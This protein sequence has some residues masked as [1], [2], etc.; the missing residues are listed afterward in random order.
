MKLSEILKT[1]GI[2]T[3]SPEV[4][5][6]HAIGKLSSSHDAA[7]V[8]DEDENLLGVI[9][10]FHCLIN[11]S[12]P[13]NAKVVNCL[14]KPPKVYLDTN[15]A[16]VARLMGESKIHYL[17]IYDEKKK[18]VG[19]ISARRILTHI[20]KLKDSNRTLSDILKKNKSLLSVF[21]D[22]KISRALH[23]F[24]KEKI[25]KLIV[26]NKDNKLKGVLTFYDLIS[27]LAAPKVREHVGDRK[28][29]KIPFLNYQVRNLMKSLVLTM[30]ADATVSEA[31]KLILDK[32]IGSIVIVDKENRPVD[33]VTT[34]D[35][36]NSV[37]RKSSSANFQVMTKNLSG[38]SRV[39]L[40]VFN[41]KFFRMIS[42]RRD[43]QRATLFIEEKGKN[44]FKVLFSLI[45]K[46]GKKEYIEREGRVL[47]EVLSDVKKTAKELE[48]KLKK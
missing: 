14:M 39:V 36:F 9:N 19:I 6:S 32:K 22:D 16:E 47:T 5:L 27:Y 33:I 8:V 46:R 10:P 12:F 31:I 41:N 40:P 35:I 37:F 26:T 43:V 28:G 45:P 2:I 17:P 4:T 44:M 7:F 24:K 3:I 23:F 25:S 38:V 42:R 1:E 48:S 18:F 13:G 34:K 21:E 29:T 20:L 30:S 11:N 15:I